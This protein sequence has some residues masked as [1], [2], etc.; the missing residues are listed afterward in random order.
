ML[1]K[2]EAKKKTEDPEGFKN[3][4]NKRSNACKA[5]K[6]AENPQGFKNDADKS[7]KKYNT[8]KKCEDPEGFKENAKQRKAKSNSNVTADKRLLK[9]RRKIQ[10]LNHYSSAP[11]CFHLHWG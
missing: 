7:R 11:A 8:R 10:T 1:K 4:A 9:F 3:D 5:G 2:S 6:K